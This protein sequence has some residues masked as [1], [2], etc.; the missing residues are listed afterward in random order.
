MEGYAFFAI[1]RNMD[2]LEPLL[3]SVMEAGVSGATI[4][5]SRGIS[6]ASFHR[7][8]SEFSVAAILSSL[9]MSE[10]HESKVLTCLVKDHALLDEIVR[11]V[12]NIVSDIDKPGSIIHFAIPVTHLRGLQE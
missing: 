9:F 1:I 6:H 3:A 7:T 4:I 8:V 5:N 10:K 2:V 12:E 11:R